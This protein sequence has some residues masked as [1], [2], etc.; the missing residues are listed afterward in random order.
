[1]SE[2]TE[3]QRD[4]LTG[5][6]HFSLYWTLISLI[7]FSLSSKI[8][9][10]VSLSLTQLLLFLV[11]SVSKK[12]S[13]PLPCP[14]ISMIMFSLVMLFSVLTQPFILLVIPNNWSSSMT[15]TLG[16]LLSDHFLL[17]VQLSPS[18]TPILVILWFRWT[19]KPWT[20]PCFHWFSPPSGPCLPLAELPFFGQSLLSSL[21]PSVLLP[22]SCFVLIAGLKPDLVWLSAA[23]PPPLR[24]E[25]GWRAHPCAVSSPPPSSG[26]PQ[27]SRRKQAFQASP[28]LLSSL[29]PL[30]VS[31]NLENRTHQERSSTCSHRPHCLLSYI[32]AHG[33]SSLFFG[34]TAP[35]LV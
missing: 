31:I 11:V 28:A 5:W 35:A 34:W 29:L 6:T 27:C 21:H 4:K 18:G 14:H 20:I 8:L 32:C 15:P 26:S 2:E 13:L 9:P 3:T 22:S 19:Y 16:L 7:T 33:L 25:C 30:L 23:L 24:S 10:P 17:Y 1:M 12:M